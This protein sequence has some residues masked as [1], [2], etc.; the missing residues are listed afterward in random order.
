[1]PV[2]CSLPFEQV[3]KGTVVHNAIDCQYMI[4]EEGRRD[5]DMPLENI[6]A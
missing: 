1:M 2:L 4:P 5:L 6:L 3:D